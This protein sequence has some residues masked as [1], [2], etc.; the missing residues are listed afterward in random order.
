[1]N[2]EAI[3]VKVCSTVKSRIAFAVGVYVNHDTTASTK[4]TPRMCHASVDAR[5][6]VVHSYIPRNTAPPAEIHIVRGTAPANS[7]RRPSA[8][9]SC[10]IRVKGEGYDGWDGS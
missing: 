7:A 2:T 1:M 8:A 4:G 5:R 9:Y 6:P 10:R 3:G